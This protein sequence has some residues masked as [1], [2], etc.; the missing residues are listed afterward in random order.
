MMERQETEKKPQFAI[1][2]DSSRGG[3]SVNLT[4]NQNQTTKLVTAFQYHSFAEQLPQLAARKPDESGGNQARLTE[5]AFG[6]DT[7]ASVDESINVERIQTSKLFERETT[8]KLSQTQSTKEQ[9]LLDQLSIAHLTHQLPPTDHKIEP[10][11]QSKDNDIIVRRFNDL[12]DKRIQLEQ[13]VK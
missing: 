12:E 10:E 7:N 8:S 5:P 2:Q 1:V 3:A 9:K 6:N 13:T 11:K 4:V